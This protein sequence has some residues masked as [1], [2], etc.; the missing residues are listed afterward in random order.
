MA[1]LQE[2]YDITLDL[3]DKRDASGN[4]NENRL[5]GIKKKFPSIATGIYAELAELNNIPLE[6]PLLY[7]L[8]DSVD[9]P[10]FTAYSVMPYGIAETICRQGGD[11]QLAD[12]MLARY[13]EM[14]KKIRIPE[15][16]ICDSERLLDGLGGRC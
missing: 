7:E 11:S 8:G 1:I 12:T 15:S 2:I 14:K 6:M 16:E 4:L 5:L 13:K 9:L 10:D 3:L